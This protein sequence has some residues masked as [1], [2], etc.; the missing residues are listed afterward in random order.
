MT[1]LYLVLMVMLLRIVLGIVVI[2]Y[3][4]IDNGVILVVRGRRHVVFWKTRN[5]LFRKVLR[6][7]LTSWP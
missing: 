1:V 7:L 4:F 5:Y 3:A 2:G 6:F